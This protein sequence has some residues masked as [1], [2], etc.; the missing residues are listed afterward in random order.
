MM[1]IGEYIQRRRKSLDLRLDDL[2]RLLAER[3]YTFGRST[4][5]N[6]ETDRHFPPLGDVGFFLAL[7]EVL[8]DD[9]LHFFAEVG[10]L[11]QTDVAEFL[12][13]VPSQ[14]RSFLW[15]LL[16]ALRRQEENG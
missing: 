6:W 5:G 1:T 2:V 8:Q 11:G 4:V 12:K 7:M 15:G 3:G 14:D 16:D 13:R 10:Y 9:P